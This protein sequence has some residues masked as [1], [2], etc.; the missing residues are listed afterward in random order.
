ME[1]QK[2]S[3]G[4]L[5]LPH[6]LTY[7]NLHIIL[8]DKPTHYLLCLGKGVI[9]LD[10]LKLCSSHRPYMWQQ[11]PQN[12]HHQKVPEWMSHLFQHD[13]LQSQLSVCTEIQGCIDD[14]MSV[15]LSLQT[16][17]SQDPSMLTNQRMPKGKRHVLTVPPIQLLPSLI[18]FTCI[19]KEARVKLYKNKKKAYG[20]NISEHHTGLLLK[21]TN[22]FTL[23]NSFSE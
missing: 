10:Q 18:K 20:C 17:Q 2:F 23:W 19:I 8:L 3:C 1:L 14:N 4:L 7:L 15:L 16:N 9:C 5:I 12:Q 11:L 13:R 22:H 21:H 6:W